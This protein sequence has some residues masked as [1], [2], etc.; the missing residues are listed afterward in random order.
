MKGGGGGG[1]GET[2]EDELVFSLSLFSSLP[3]GPPRNNS[4]RRSEGAGGSCGVQKYGD[5]HLKTGE[6]RRGE[7]RGGRP[8]QREKAVRGEFRSPKHDAEV[9]FSARGSYWRVATSYFFFY[10]FRVHTCHLDRPTSKY[11]SHCTSG[12]GSVLCSFKRNRCEANSRKDQE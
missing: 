8:Q 9:L 10:P 6:G 11:S 3:S 4:G 7:V 1:G 5:A 12:P 2:L